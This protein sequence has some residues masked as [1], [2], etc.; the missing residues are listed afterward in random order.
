MKKII[1]IICPFLF[2]LLSCHVIANEE[3]IM[4]TMHHEQ[5]NPMI[6]D[7]MKA[8]EKMH[9]PMMEGIMDQDPDVAFIKGMMPH[10]Q[11]AIDMAKIE[12]K[13]G[14]DPK[15]KALAEEIIKAQ[16]KE[17]A[18]MQQWLEQHNKK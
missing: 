17:I 10:H 16:K 2:V 7:Y 4:K 11:G 9:K 18:Q 5:T 1:T 15:T 13:Y 3:H 6:T 14:K 8:M 12:L